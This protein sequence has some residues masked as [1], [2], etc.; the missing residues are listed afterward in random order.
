[1]V[2]LVF[3]L[4]RMDG[5]V[6]WLHFASL[7]GI[8]YFVLAAIGYLMDVYWGS[9][10][11]ERNGFTVALFTLYFPQVVSGPVTRF[12]AMKEQFD[13]LHKPEYQNI[14]YGMRRMAWGYFKKLV[15]SERFAIVVTTVFGNH[16][17]YSG[18]QIL[19][20]CL[21][22]F[23]R[24]YTDFSGC[25]DIVLGA[26]QLFG[27]QLPENFKAPFYSKSIK[28]FWQ[29]WHITLG[30][31]FKD[32]VMYPV[33][34]SGPF[35]SLGKK[36]KKRFGKKNGKKIPTY[37]AM[38]ILWFLLGVWHGGTAQYFIASAMIPFLLLI[39]GDLLEPLF[40]SV[41]KK[42]GIK[43]E[44]F[45]FSLFQRGR[46]MLLLCLCWVF[47]CTGTVQEGF[48]VLGQMTTGFFASGTGS[49]SPL[50][51]GFVTTD[52][53]LMILGVLTLLF[54]HICLEKENAFISRFYRKH[55]AVRYAVIYAEILLLLFFG[56]VGSSTFIYFKF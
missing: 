37:I 6:S 48:A 45:V 33:Q 2:H 36:C 38:F 51:F 21:C 14:A 44:S 28:E 8:S 25:M 20:A 35:V 3:G 32:Y 47:V 17:E 53:I 54:E 5:D 29:R 11:A 7:M 10:K 1:M 9:Y 22:Y 56:M 34:I 26:S 46:T 41:K 31:W 19:L 16:A 23:I 13:T 27:I 24:L 50:A 49:M 4:F 52:V 15:I 18:L 12:P 55:R 42:L 40:V 43:E 39:G 30:N